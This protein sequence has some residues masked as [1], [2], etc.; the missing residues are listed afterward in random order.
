M[1]GGLWLGK[2]YFKDQKNQNP[3][4]RVPKLKGSCLCKEGLNEPVFK[5]GERGEDN[6]AAKGSRQS[7]CG[8][9]VISSG[10]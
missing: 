9:W 4:V 5:R 7:G 10:V 8:Q 3:Q 6:G 2:I 1:G